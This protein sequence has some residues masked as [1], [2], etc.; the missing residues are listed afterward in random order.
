MFAY[1]RFLMAVLAGLL[2]PAGTAWA[3]EQVAPQL[4][5]TH[6]FQF[7][8]YYAA[9]EKGYYREAGLDV[10]L[11]EAM[12]GVDPLEAVLSGRAQ[13]GVGTSSLPP[14]RSSNS[15]PP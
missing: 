10:Q 2:A 1:R 6:A 13:Y 11:F 14:G 12:P 7:A 3:L 9:L 8:G 5:W 15:G 4:K